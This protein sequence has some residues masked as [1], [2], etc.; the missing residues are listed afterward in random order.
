MD[1]YAKPPPFWFPLCRQHL[2]KLATTSEKNNQRHWQWTPLFGT[3]VQN[4]HLHEMKQLW[5][6]NALRHPIFLSQ[7]QTRKRTMKKQSWQS[8]KWQSFKKRDCGFYDHM[9]S[10]L[11]T[12]QWQLWY[13]PDE[14]DAIPSECRREA[15]CKITY[16]EYH[17][18]YISEA[19]PDLYTWV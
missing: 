13:S 14:T 6:N 16:S 9:P 15:I 10:K 11:L 19:S 7:Q 18:I 3:D 4:R 12:D 5:R 8:L 2:G 1:S 17:A